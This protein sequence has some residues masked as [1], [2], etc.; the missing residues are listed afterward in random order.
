MNRLT[1]MI[2]LMMLTTLLVLGLNL[3][4]QPQ[5][6]RVLAADPCSSPTHVGTLWSN[7]GTQLARATFTNETASGWQQVNFSNPVAITANTVYVASYHTTV[8]R[9]AYD[10]GF[11]ANSGVDTLPL[12]ALRNGVNGGN[13]VYTSSSTPAFPTSTYQSSNY[14]VDVVFTTTASADTT[15][16]TVSSTTPITGATG[17]SNGTSVTATFSE[18]MDSTTINGSTFE[19]RGTNNALVSANVTYNATNRTITLIPSSS[20][21]A[22]TT[23]TATIKGGTTGVKD[24]AGNALAANFTWS[25]TTAAA[26]T[27][28]PTVTSVSPNSGATGVSTGTSVTATFNEAMDSTTISGSTF[29]LRNPSNTLVSAT[30]S[31]NATNRTV[32]LTPSSPLVASTTYTTTIK[33]GTTGVKDSA[34]NALAAN[35]TWSFTTGAGA[36][37]IWNNTVTPTVL[38]DPDNTAVEV[39][40][41]F[42]SDVSGS[43]TGIRFYKSTIN[44]GTHVATLWSNTGTQLA[45]ATF[46]LCGAT[47]VHNWQGQLLAT[48]LLQV[49]SRLTLLIQ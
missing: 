8:G 9:Y 3:G 29:E 48:K 33:G 13:G 35:F 24:S 37:S 18:A 27:T 36:S 11:F 26:D 32:T 23:Y 47:L 17:V 28:P 5:M 21:A 7:T 46:R 22:S 19:L 44:T 20:L 2:I 40:V 41:K 39:G 4:S 43:I 25:F 34:G 12:H 42:R 14:W 30:A 1:R 45:R 15:P 49:G 38:A 31:Y 10:N 16:P 6:Q